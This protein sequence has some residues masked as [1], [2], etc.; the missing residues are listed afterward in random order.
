[1]RE[2]ILYH[3]FTNIEKA[4]ANMSSTLIQLKKEHPEII[5][6]RFHEHI[7]NGIKQVL[8]MAENLEAAFKDNYS[9]GLTPGKMDG[10]GN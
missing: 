7:V 3:Q 6:A 10:S 8:A 5:E 4:V 2:E 1:M 9:A